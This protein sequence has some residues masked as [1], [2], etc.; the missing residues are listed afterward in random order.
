M[1]T[2]DSKS[3]LK[4]FFETRGIR[5]D[6]DP[7]EVD[8]ELQKILPPRRFTKYQK[9]AYTRAYE[10]SRTNEIYQAMATRVEANTLVS[11][12][13]E[14]YLDT[15]AAIF[16]AM[17]P[18]LTSG[19][20]VWEMGCMNGICAEWLA[21]THPEIRVNAVDKVGQV[22]RDAANQNSL[23]NLEYI[24][25]DYSKRFPRTEFHEADVIYMCSSV[26]NQQKWDTFVKGRSGGNGG[27]VGLPQ[28]FV[29]AFA[30][31]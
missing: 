25:W 6:M 30:L 27:V 22:L 9:A 15:N 7:D 12:Q 23:E 5:F 16:K 10:G 13:A 29:V 31:V 18:Y 14:V 20:T 2:S 1:N 17:E 24:S 4:S 3:N 28:Q 21:E 26:G 11:Q 8:V 19:K